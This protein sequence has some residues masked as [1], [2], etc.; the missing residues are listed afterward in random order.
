MAPNWTQLVRFLAEEDGQIHLGEVD[1]KQYPDVGLAAMNG[2]RITAQLINGSIFDGIVTEKSLHIAQVGHLNNP[3]RLLLTNMSPAS[4]TRW[5][6]R[7]INHPVLGTQLPRSC[8]RSEHAHPRC[9][10]SLCETSH[11]IEWVA[12]SKDQCAQD[13]TGWL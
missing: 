9:T 11:C 3:T 12:P 5:D 6:R 13:R 10:S 7:R 4:L 2:E 1:A 8:Q